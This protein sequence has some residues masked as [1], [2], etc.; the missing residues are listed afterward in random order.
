MNDEKHGRFGMI[1]DVDAV[2]LH[3][4]VFSSVDPASSDV[5]LNSQLAFKY[6]AS[7]PSLFHDRPYSPHLF[8]ILSVPVRIPFYSRPTLFKAVWRVEPF[9][10]A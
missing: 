3:A 8:L 10:R 5:I 9:S 2:F 6:R 1:A 7:F 4:D